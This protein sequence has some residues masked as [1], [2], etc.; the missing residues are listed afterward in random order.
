MWKYVESIFAC[1]KT[2]EELFAEWISSYWCIMSGG[3]DIWAL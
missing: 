1:Y 2:Q 3:M